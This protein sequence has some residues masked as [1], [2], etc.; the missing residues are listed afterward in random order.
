MCSN[1]K[2]KYSILTFIIGK[3]Y[4]KVHEISNKQEDVEYVL[5]TDD[6]ELKSNT[7]NRQRK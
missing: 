7:W 2:L 1:N 3:N 6:N 4:E 5:V